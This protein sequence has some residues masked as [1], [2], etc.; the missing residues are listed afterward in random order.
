MDLLIKRSLSVLS[1]TNEGFCSEAHFQHE[2][3]LQLAQAKESQ[4]IV[5]ERSYPCRNTERKDIYLDLWIKTKRGSRV[6]IELKYKT[7]KTSFLLDGEEV[8]LQNHLATDLGRYGFWKDVARIESLIR[9]GELDYGYVIFLTNAP[10]YWEFEGKYNNGHYTQDRNF[11]M[12][13]GRLISA[14]TV[15]KWD[16][17]RGKIK[18]LENDGKK[19]W[20]EKYEPIRL[21]GHYQIP[22]WQ[23]F[24]T[25]GK[26]RFLLMK[27]LCSKMKDLCIR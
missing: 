21:S 23:D 6:G 17:E 26:F 27:V 19:H 16:I 24:S 5:V 14:G 25:D 1:E 22:D 8:V 12:T 18:D 2:L 11:Y 3:A 4:R 7:A 13:G 20:T 15:L 9:D 10:S